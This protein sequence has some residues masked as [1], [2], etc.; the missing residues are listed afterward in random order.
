MVC[1]RSS[2]PLPGAPWADTV[3]PPRS[4]LL[5]YIFGSLRDF[6]V[7]LVHGAV[8]KSEEVS[9]PPTAAARPSREST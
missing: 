3:P 6:W 8:H 7:K 9:S 1:L 5:L 4:L 2:R